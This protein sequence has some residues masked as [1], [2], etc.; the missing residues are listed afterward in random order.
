VT[1]EQVLATGAKPGTPKFAKTWSTMIAAHLNARPRKVLPEEIPAPP[2]PPQQ[3][4]AFA[5][6]IRR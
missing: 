5:R 2:P 6:G 1:E 3:T 4:S